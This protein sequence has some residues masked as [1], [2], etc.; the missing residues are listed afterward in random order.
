MQKGT[1][2]KEES[3]KK[4]SSSRK[5]LLKTEE[6]KQNISEAMKRAWAKRKEEANAKV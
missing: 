2:H 4:M 5:N 3:K 1:T 6:H